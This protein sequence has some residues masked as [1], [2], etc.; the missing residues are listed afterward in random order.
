MFSRGEK[1]KVAGFSLFGIQKEDRWES[2]SSCFEGAFRPFFWRCGFSDSQASGTS[3]QNGGGG[4][5][6]VGGYALARVGRRRR[7]RKSLVVDGDS[8]RDW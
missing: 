7:Y 2:L 4:G 3:S 6:Q 5:W 1:P 8:V